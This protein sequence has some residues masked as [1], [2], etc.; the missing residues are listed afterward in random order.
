MQH[1]QE[2]IRTPRLI[3]RQWQPSDLPVYA[4]L[5]ADPE[6]RR[7]WPTLLTRAQSDEQAEGFQRH[8]EEHGFG[9]WALEVPG[10]A[11]F[12]GFTG[13]MRVDSS[14]PF[15][16]GVE[17]GWR[18]A[19]EHWGKGYVTEA[20]RAALADGFGRLGLSEIVSY[21]VVGNEASFSVMKRIG[22]NRDQ[23]GDLD[24]PGREALHRRAELYRVHRNQVNA[25]NG[26]SR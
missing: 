8:I 9:F 15:A 22:M 6:V 3:L 2:P 26:N 4:A 1:S 7:F 24:I 10:V 12:V 25:A 11:P 5:N 17:I 21:A 13:L 23:A 14:M 20:A 19:R 18:L 16:P